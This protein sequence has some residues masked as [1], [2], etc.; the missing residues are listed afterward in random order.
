[1]VVTNIRY[2]GTLRYLGSLG[3][4]NTLATHLSELESGELEFILVYLFFSRGTKVTV[5][6]AMLCKA[7]KVWT[8]GAG[9]VNE[10]AMSLLGCKSKPVLVT[11]VSLNDLNLLQIVF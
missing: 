6:C 5:H 11:D 7:A 8:W 10:L 2:V 4:T 3:Q 9:H 1:M